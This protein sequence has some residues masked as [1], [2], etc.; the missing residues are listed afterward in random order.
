[1]DPITLI[2]LGVILGGAAVIAMLTWSM[3]RREID[4]SKIPCGFAKVI[5]EGLRG[6]YHVVTIGVFSSGG[7]RQRSKTWK[8]KNLD[9][10]LTSRLAQAGGTIHVTT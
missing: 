8:A 1:M 4:V 2:V 5:D 9:H 7:V 10:D 6:Q 3:V